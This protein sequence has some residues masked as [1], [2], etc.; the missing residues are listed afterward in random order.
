MENFSSIE[1]ILNELSKKDNKLVIFCGAGISINSGLP[2]AIPLLN[3]ILEHLEV[4]L[5]DKEKLIKPDWTLAMPFEMFFEIFLENSKD[6]Q[7]LDVFKDGKPSTNH[8]FILK[9]HQHNLMNEIYTTNFDLLIEKAFEI[10][11]TDL[12]V[13]KNEKSFPAIDIASVKCRL[14]KV[15]GSID[16]IESIRTTLT[17]ITNKN[18]TKER[19]KVLDNIFSTKE[20]DRRILILGYSCS[21]IFDI[22]PKIEKIF[23]PKVNVYLIEYDKSIDRKEK[24]IIED[25]CQKKEN[26]PFK[27]YKGQ[28]IKVNTDLFVKWLWNKIDSDYTSTSDFNENWKHHIDKWIKAFNSR[29]L[30]FTII[31]QLFYRI[32]NYDI[33]LKYHQKALYANEENK[34]NEGASYSNIGLIYHALKDYK[35]A[36]EYFEKA[37]NIFSEID[38]YFGIAAANTNLGYSYI[39]LSDRIRAI[40]YLKKSLQVSRKKEFREKKLCESDTLCNLGELYEK[41]AEYYNAIHYYTLALDIDKQ[42]NKA[43]EAQTLS[44]LGRV[45]KLMGNLS[46]SLKM[47]KSSNDIAFKVGLQSLLEYT[48][49]QIEEIKIKL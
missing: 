38:F 16:D 9:C 22:V 40:K 3:Q 27:R 44:D 10:N 33:A 34:K 6:F 13:F 19:G 15:H 48:N 24:V 31:G 2:A 8:W 4:D 7:I 12:L 29:Y 17:T 45:Y 41:E 5:E 30:M 36:I 23:D 35:K 46:S 43:G 20:V 49:Q 26:N 1:N 18:L 25:I 37:L 28:R 32:S 39:Y 11:K 47:F 42:G 21:D 14:V